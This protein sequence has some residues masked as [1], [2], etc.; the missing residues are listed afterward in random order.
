MTLDLEQIEKLKLYASNFF[1]YRQCA[2]LLKLD[3][4]DFIEEADDEDSEI[5]EI[6]H[7]SFLEKELEIKEQL[8]SMATMGSPAAQVEASKLIEKTKAENY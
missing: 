4:D 2:I 5:F 6:Y 1:T 8:I 3:I 7:N